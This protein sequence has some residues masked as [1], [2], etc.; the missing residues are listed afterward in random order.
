MT[1]AT[2]PSFGWTKEQIVDWNEGALEALRDHLTSR[3]RLPA[4]AQVITQAVT[5][6]VKTAV[7][8]TKRLRQSQERIDVSS[9]KGE[10]PRRGHVSG[11]LLGSRISERTQKATAYIIEQKKSGQLRPTVLAI[12]KTF[13]V[14]DSWARQCIAEHYGPS[15]YSGAAEHIA[16]A[17]PRREE[18]RKHLRTLTYRPRVVD[19]AQQFHVSR[20][21]AAVLIRSQFGSARANQ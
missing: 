12:I 18:V 19:I 20:R 17:E 6:P 13:G 21:H 15:S 4:S 8:K 16:R 2:L 10:A 9:R 5:K 3:A 14:S 11:N 1:T 7:S